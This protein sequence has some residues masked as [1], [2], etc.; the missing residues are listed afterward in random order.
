MRRWRIGQGGCSDLARPPSG[1]P[2][3]LQI[4]LNGL[5][6]PGGVSTTRNLRKRTNTFSG[7]LSE[8][9][10]GHAT[11]DCSGLRADLAKWLSKR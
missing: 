9:K 10:K 5:S 3:P 11:I 1:A 2:A 6:A 7:S 8:R 4:A